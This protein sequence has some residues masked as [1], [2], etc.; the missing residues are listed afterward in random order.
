MILVDSS[1]WIE[2]FT[3]GPLVQSFEPFLADEAQVITPT[4]VL[5]EVY[6]LIRRERSEEEALTAVA[7]MKRTRLV[8]L[9]ETIALTAADLGLEHRLAMADSIVYATARVER[10][11][12]VT[13][14]EDF[15]HLPAVTYFAKKTGPKGRAR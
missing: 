4:I 5:Y 1:G 10:A 13:S 3:D 2:L 12:L 9:S 14:D 15:A 6:R 7:A 8:P 11:E